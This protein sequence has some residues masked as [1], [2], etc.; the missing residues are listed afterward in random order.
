MNLDSKYYS[1]LSE[2]GV[3]TGKETRN[4]AS[5]LKKA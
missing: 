5:G 2:K 3:D 1:Q 4:I